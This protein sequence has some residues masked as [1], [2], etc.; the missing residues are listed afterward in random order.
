MEG[1]AGTAL[2]RLAV[3]QTDPIGLT[4]GDD[5]KRAAMSLR[6]SFHRFSSYRGVSTPL[7]PIFST[8]VEPLRSEG[9]SSSGS[10]SSAEPLRSGP[11]H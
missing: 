7:W 8:D 5:A 10:G 3:T 2:T 9:S 11:P 4:R 6:G 1:G